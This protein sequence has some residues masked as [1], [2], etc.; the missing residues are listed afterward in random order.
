MITASLRLSIRGKQKAEAARALR[1][2][3]GPTRAQP[4]CVDSRV[5]EELDEADVLLYLEEW[6]S[7]EQLE[8]HIR[9]EQYRRLL[10]IMEMASER[11]ELRFDVISKRMGLELVEAVR[12]G[13]T[14]PPAS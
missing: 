5:F 8:R 14:A 13:Q 1:S 9:S 7:L 12:A 10:A 4:G 6:E 11:P 2:L 3:T